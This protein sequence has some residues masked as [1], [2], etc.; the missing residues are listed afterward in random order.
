M[1]K[2]TTY[3]L[4][5][6]TLLS[7]VSF[8]GRLQDADFKT[9]TELGGSGNE[10]KLLNDTKVYVTSANKR[11]SDA[12]NDGDIGGGGGG[13][14]VNLL[15]KSDNTGFESGLTSWTASGGTTGVETAAPLFGAKS[16][17][18]DASA[19]NQ[20]FSSAAKT[21]VEGL[22]VQPC[23][24]LVGYKY[25][26][27]DNDYS[28]Q[29]YD[30]TNVL[31]ETLLPAAAS[32]STAYVAF[33][34]PASGS[35]SLRFVSKV[36]SPGQITIDGSSLSGGNIHLG[37]NLLLASRA[38]ASL[39][40]AVVIT[41][42][43]AG[44]STTSGSFADFSTQTGCTYTTYGAALAPSTNI[45][46]IKFASLPPGEYKIEVEGALE[47]SPTS[48]SSGGLLRIFDGTNGARE[49]SHLATS[50]GSYTITPTMIGSFGYSSAQSNVTFSIQGRLQSG[51]GTTYVGNTSG[52][53]YSQTVLRVYRM[54]TTQQATVT[55]LDS[56]S[57]TYTGS[58][59]CYWTTTS[60]SYVDPTNGT[61]CVL[62][63]KQ[64]L[65]FG[66]VTNPSNLPAVT[67]TPKRLGTYHVCVN[68]FVQSSALVNANIQLVDGSGT[69]IAETGTN[70]GNNTPASLCG[71]YNVTSL[72]AVTLKVQARNGGSGTA[73]V[74]W[75]GA[76]T[77]I[78]IM[79]VTQSVPSPYFVLNQPV[80][81]GTNMRIESAT[82]AN[83]GSASVLRQT[84][85]WIQSVSRTAAGRVTVTFVGSIFSSTPS[86]SVTVASESGGS[87]NRG[88]QILDQSAS[89]INIGTQIA[90][91]N[92]D[93]DMPFNVM[94]M[95]AK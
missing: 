91:T 58:L 59:A 1:K 13:G 90:T 2:F 67:F 79:D 20:T 16:A 54:P 57:N 35:V 5:F 21:V 82:V 24:G 32:T 18:W 33:G 37:S 65:N 61:S 11:L 53:S 87:T 25:G 23:M 60:S 62:T 93:T 34:C 40:G 3:L 84:G 47:F 69:Q 36:A 95:G 45:P 70:N 38:D 15:T 75:G 30:G 71:N 83:S 51:S 66:T 92:S 31:G 85:T 28:I 64:N 22:K 46:A 73:T 26:G 44:W 12:I 41:G 7:N 10:P 4:L 94:C 88:I 48:G 42:C 72:S 29:A 8:A 19:L 27:A 80:S 14:G 9:L 56:A 81:S 86:C 49:L 68:T 50:N 39:V 78:S 52:G 55:G 43:S 17:N 6:A 63:E 77:I 74:G 89:A 76:P